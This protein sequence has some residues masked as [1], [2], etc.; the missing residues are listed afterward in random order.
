MSCAICGAEA[1]SEYCKKCEKILDEIIHRVGEKRWS[2]M[3]D[4]SYIY[5]MIK[6][7]AKGELSVND[8]INAMEV[9][10]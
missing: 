9:E 4:C 5:P 1:D 6:R 7:A 8:I 2:A 3:D 10:D